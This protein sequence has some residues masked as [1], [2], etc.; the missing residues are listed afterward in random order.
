MTTD[1]TEKTDGAAPQAHAFQAEVA[2][3]L[4][5]MVHSVY[6]NKDIFLREL[7]SNAADACERL[8]HSALTAPELI[9]D[10]PDFAIRLEVDAE[11]KRLVVS[12]NGIGMTRDEMIANLGTIARS[13]T[14]AFMDK[15][16][17]AND[18]SALIGQ[19][20]VGFYSAFMVADQVEVVSRAA[21][22]EEAWRWTSDGMGE[23]TVEPVDLA[24]AP[25]RGSRVVLHLKDDALAYAQAGE[26]ERVVRSYSAHVPVPIL[27]L[28]VQAKA[29]E[30]AKADE[31]LDDATD[32]DVNEQLGRAPA[33]RQLADG[34]ALWT[35]SKSEVSE[36]EYKEFYG[37]VS[38][39]YDDPALT[40]HYRAEGRHE[41]SVLVFLPSM[42][43]FDLFDPDRKGRVKLYVRRVFIADDVDLLPA[44]LRFARGVI[45][46]ADL[47]LN[48][49]R[50]MLQHNPVLE[51][52]RKG[53]TNRILSELQKLSEND[54]ETFLK[55]WENFGPVLKEGIYEDF[56]RKDKLLALARFRSSRDKGEGWRTL[57]DYVADM[58]E[59]QT[60]IFYATGSSVEAIASSPHLEGFRARGVEVLYLADPVDAFWV[61]MAQGFEGK[62]FQSV[63]QGA[64]ALD[65][66]PVDDDKAEEA[67]AKDKD[68]EGAVDIG[69]VTAFL[70]ETLGESVSDVRSSARLSESPV[71]L[72]APEHG[73]DRQLEKLMARQQGGASGAF[74]P[75]LEFNPSHALVGGMS[76]RLSADGDKGE[77]AD[78]AWLL[79][80]QAR[81]L[82]GDA[83]S[84]AAAFARRL[85]DVMRKG[86]V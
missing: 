14:R 41:Y 13:G 53:V 35:K 15:L 57:A 75:V 22:S 71:C 10:D 8:R 21:G 58:K 63:T 48:L 70:K 34:T 30:D 2:R 37:H 81:I 84:D 44:W 67:G 49:S 45:D 77:L 18:G 64:A 40:L 59:N 31:D 3:L 5:L 20:G 32:E 47:P 12:D 85:G 80:D 4:H 26:V 23:F 25:A 11:A 66:I 36:E 33:E 61:Q 27:L 43:P 50:E 46:S 74:A 9:R 24:D 83:P 54:P 7:V 72:V 19:F 62:P 60:Q 68:V 1:T 86:L 82:D 42:K 51:S 29:A 79:F 56:E 38:G 52:I 39:Q 55:I 28:D 73:P 76:K 78:M 69:L 6:S 65:A 16:G 17:E